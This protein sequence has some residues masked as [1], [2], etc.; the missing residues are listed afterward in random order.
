MRLLTAALA[1]FGLGYADAEAEVLRPLTGLAS[2][3]GKEHAGHIM[4]NGRPFDP[5]AMTCATYAYPLGTVLRVA[6]GRR[7]VRV[8]VTDRGPHPRLGRLV[9][10]SRRAFLELA[11][12][13]FGLVTVTVSVASP[14]RGSR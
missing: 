5:E 9:D 11:P 4:A 12:L 13:D 8:L 2:W 14:E 1:L 6:Y 7:T 3:Y 10:L